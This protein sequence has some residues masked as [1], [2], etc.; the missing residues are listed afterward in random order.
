MSAK[1]LKLNPIVLRPNQEE[2]MLI[3]KGEI[4]RVNGRLLMTDKEHLIGMIHAL[5]VAAIS[6]EYPD[7][8]IPPCNRR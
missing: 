4:D 2:D 3:L 7:A 6:R 8:D 1:I 5:A